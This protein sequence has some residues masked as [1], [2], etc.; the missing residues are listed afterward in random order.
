[1]HCSSFLSQLLTDAF[2]DDCEDLAD[3]TTVSNQILCR[4]HESHGLLSNA[5]IIR[6]KTGRAFCHVLR[7][8][9]AA[10]V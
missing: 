3:G 8:E 1:M 9:N 10:L 6:T 5:A 7:G 4:L 2:A